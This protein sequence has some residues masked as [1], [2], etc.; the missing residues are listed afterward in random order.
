MTTP[1]EQ[2]RL[3]NIAHNDGTSVNTGL[4]T[5]CIRKRLVQ[6]VGRVQYRM[7]HPMFR[8]YVI[9]VSGNEIGP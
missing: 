5:Q 1:I 6:Q 2:K 4:V 3:L 8:D 7:Y 9:S